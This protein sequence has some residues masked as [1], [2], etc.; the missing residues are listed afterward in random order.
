MPH[1]PVVSGNSSPGD[2]PTNLGG[3]RVWY[4]LG[5]G[6]I[7]NVCVPFT[8]EQRRRLAIKGKRLTP[9]EREA[10]CQIVRPETILRWFRHL[11][12]KK[13]DSSAKRR[14]LARPR[15]GNDIRL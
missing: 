13:Y 12:A 14:G 1:D 4:L 7:L 6:R 5:G 10:C 9:E 2:S 11:A 8:D 3:G 15:K